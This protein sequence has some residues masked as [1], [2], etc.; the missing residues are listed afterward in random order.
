MR[1]LILVEGQTEER[2]VK[3][4]IA[5][6]FWAMNLFLDP[7]ILVTKKVKD[8]P[9]FKGGVTS[10]DRCKNDLSKLLKSS[11]GA[12]VTTM[13]DYYGLPHDFPGMNSRP[14]A[15]ARERAQ[16]VQSA[17]WADLGAPSNFVPFLAVHEFEAWL[18]SCPTTLPNVL[19]MPNPSPEF[20]R[21][22]SY[23]ESPEEI[24]DGHETAPSKR[25]VNIF[26]AYKKTL[27]GPTAAKRIGLSKI[28]SAC[29]H[30]NAWLERLES[31]APGPSSSSNELCAY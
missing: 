25:I 26:P 9:N 29:P 22:C 5:P 20:A 18:F 4:T 14:N 30:F 7:T 1:G 10:Y 8:G 27:H 16:H 13:L 21:L 6:A 28:R 19:T 31:M 23:Y 12:L 3:D 24:N 17:L 15:S 2:L 11:G